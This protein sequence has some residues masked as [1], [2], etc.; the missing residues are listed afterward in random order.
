MPN[1]K[2]KNI[3]TPSLFFKYAKCPHWI[4][5]DFYS[6]EKEKAEE[7]ELVSKI[8]EQGVIH[9]DAY[10]KDLAFDKVAEED[11]E[12]A[13]EETL[14]LMRAGSELIYQ[15]AIQY[16]ADG[17]IYRG[18]PDLMEKKKGKSKFGD[19]YYAPVDI[20]SSKAISKEQESQLLTY[21]IIL[22]Q[23]QDYFPDELAIINK[24]GKRNFLD[25][26]NA[27][28]AKTKELTEKI[29]NIMK[30]R[31]PSLKLTSSCKE[32]PWFAK[33]VSEAEEKDDIALI[34]RL[35]SRAHPGLRG[36]GINTVHDL[37][38]ADIGA[39]PKIPYASPEKLEKYKLQAQSLIDKEIKRIGELE[40]PEAPLKIYF[41]IEGD[42]LLQVEYL[43]GFWIVGDPDRKYA[44]HENVV[45]DEQEKKYFIYFL[46]EKPEAEEEMWNEFLGWLEILPKDYLVY[47]YADYERSK[48]LSMAKKYRSSPA[49]EYFHAKLFDFSKVIQ[50]AV[51]FPVYFY[52]IK[53][54]AKHLKYKWRHEKAGG[55]QSIFWYEKWLETEDRKVLRDIVNYNEDDVRATEFLHNWLV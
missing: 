5:H 18:R 39:L 24:E 34:Y 12:K 31:K 35:D 54:L 22:E 14:K 33:C 10:V 48:T 40:I 3:F 55:A 47:H 43:F 29:I 25:I 23:M 52:S 50:E 45:Y 38:K 11:P 42:P 26:D 41:D 21:G 15:G 6:D 32:S 17:V 49:F 2:D 37:A 30:G 19:Y 53:D 46:A 44:K 20:K 8:R 1:L 36:E 4:W 51:I 28:I 7:P 16:E 13:Y 9:E 27:D